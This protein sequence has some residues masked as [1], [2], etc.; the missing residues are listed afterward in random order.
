MLDMP[1][2]VL[3]RHSLENYIGGGSV[4]VGLGWGAGTCG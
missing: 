1:V 2:V 3:W 4:G